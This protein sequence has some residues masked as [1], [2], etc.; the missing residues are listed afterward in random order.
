M[1]TIKKIADLLNISPTTVSNVI[2]GKTKEVSNDTIIKVQNK[3]KELNYVPNMNARSLAR[4]S[5][6]IIGLIIRYPMMNGKNAFQDPFNS[7]LI[8]TIE[9]EVRKAGYFLM[10][11]VTDK[12]SDIL[13]LVSTWNVDGI[14]IVGLGAKE[15]K[16]VND[17]S[18]KPV[19][20]IDCYFV[21]DANQYINVGLK[22]KEYA[23]TMT[24]Y[25]ISQGHKK[26]AFLAD[27]CVGVDLERWKGFKQALC[28]N[29]LAI[30][31]TNFIRI[32]YKKNDIFDSLK[33]LHGRLSEFTALFFASDYY[34]VLGINFLK[35]KGIHIP[36]DI[37]VVGFD[38][39]IFGRYMCPKL[40]TVHQNPG[41]K[42][43]IA[44]S[45][46]LN[47][48]KNEPVEQTN[49]CLDAELI[50]RDSVRNIRD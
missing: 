26:I 30:D 49:I 5:S 19:I 41:E 4:N 21:D 33:E 45:L 44:M 13:T 50:I 48:L 9:Y 32:D 27:N 8:G 2:H 46:L 25:L 40:T 14:I 36:N 42:G 10:L 23:K 12:A 35:D 17:T 1:I 37:S 15:C 31:Q 38:D 29:N 24:E 18:D 11:Y 3:I 20:F 22:D 47:I 39:N 43:R 28:E 34:A 7:E 6:K 16:Q